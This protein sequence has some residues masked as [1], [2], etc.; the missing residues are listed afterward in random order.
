MIPDAQLGV[1]VLTNQESGAAFDSIAYHILD[2]YLGAPAVRLDRRVTGDRD[3]RGGGRRA[4]RATR[5]RRR[6]TRA[7]RPSLPLA[8]YAG[9]YRDAWYGDIDDRGSEAAALAMRFSHTPSLVRRRSSTGSTTRSSS[10]GAIASCAP[11]PSSRSR[12]TR[13]APSIRRRCEAVSP[14]TDF[15]FDF[16]DLLLRPVK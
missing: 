14:E 8:K 3:A 9:T 10:A 6:A 4:E 15:S 2:H 16:Q 11:T 1:A 13:T 12:S 7:S 5:A